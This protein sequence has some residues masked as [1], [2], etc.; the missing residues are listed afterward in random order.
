MLRVFIISAIVIPTLYILTSP[1]LDTGRSLGNA[2]TEVMDEI[3]AGGGSGPR[4]A[5]RRMKQWGGGV[6]QAEMPW[7]DGAETLPPEVEKSGPDAILD[8]DEDMPV[9]AYDGGKSS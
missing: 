4:E 6:K 2:A 3:K 1:T 5:L 9:S 7:A 8:M